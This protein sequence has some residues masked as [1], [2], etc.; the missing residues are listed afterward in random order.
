MA[1]LMLRLLPL[2]VL[3]TTLCSLANII[4][5]RNM[6]PDE[7][8]AFSFFLSTIS[9][10]SLMGLLGFQQTLPRFLSLYG[11]ERRP[12][13]AFGF[14]ITAVVLVIAA[15]ALATVLGIYAVVPLILNT[16]SHQCLSDGYY[17]ATAMALVTLCSAY[18]TYHRQALVSSSAGSDGAIYQFV[19]IGTVLL[20][21]LLPHGH[22]G[23][24]AVEVVAAMGLAV[25]ACLAVELV[26]C[27][28]RAKDQFHGAPGFRLREWLS[29]TLPVGGSAILGTLVYSA[30]IIAVR[31]IAGSGSAA[32]YAVASSLATF[33]IIPRAASTTY[34]SQE[35]PHL[36]GPDRS[37]ALQWLIRRALGFSLLAAA[38]LGV[39][40]AIFNQPLLG[41]YGQ[42]YLA[43]WP[44]LL[45]L[46][47][48]RLL[49]A[50]VSIGVQLLNLEGYGK[51]LVVM[52][53][54]TG[55]AFIAL[56]VLLVS[57]LGLIG[58]APAVLLFML[59]SS[60]L[61]YRRT[62]Q[63][64]GLRLAPFVLTRG[65]RGAGS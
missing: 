47:L 54:W 62:L 18:L 25:G 17:L 64:T 50:P 49:E 7:Y 20:A 56:L 45:L 10:L 30:D 21:L 12:G 28:I 8:G 33:V 65:P 60:A 13:L 32:A 61:F 51:K 16:A 22:A 4:L 2:I 19:L 37:D 29:E 38:C 1:P 9:L 55:V 43:V 44:A 23:L 63:H 57:W 35:A 41:L 26:W 58:A 40:M 27:S 31:L 53:L 14:M 42:N 6:S 59:L 48:A 52:N 15:T 11:R 5:T 34:F 36:A 46:L 39:L 3:G 24:L